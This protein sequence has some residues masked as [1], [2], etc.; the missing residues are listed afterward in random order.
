MTRAGDGSRRADLVRSRQ[1]TPFRKCR[2]FFPLA[3]P[4]VPVVDFQIYL[5]PLLAQKVDRPVCFLRIFFALVT[6]PLF[7]ETTL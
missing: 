7:A 1:T 2:L 3:G 5:C 6:G 4:T